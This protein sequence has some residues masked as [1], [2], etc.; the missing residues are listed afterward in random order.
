MPFTARHERL[1]VQSDVKN[2]LKQ[3]VKIG[4]DP[5]GRSYFWTIAQHRKLQDIVPHGMIKDV[6]ARIIKER[7]G[8]ITPGY[9]DAINVLANVHKLWRSSIVTG[10]LIPRYRYFWNNF[11]GDFSQ[12]WQTMG[13]AQSMETSF[14]FAVGIP[15]WTKVFNAARTLQRRN[16]ELILIVLCPA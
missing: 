10:R 3:L 1:R 8:I 4:D 7:T 16:L 5:E 12:I 6:S 11:Y 9:K 2:I 13:I 15:M 14:N